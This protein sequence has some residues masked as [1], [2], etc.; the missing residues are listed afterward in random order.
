METVDRMLQVNLEREAHAHEHFKSVCT[1]M[2][3]D[4][5]QMKYFLNKIF[6]I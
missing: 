3:S 5:F 2:V 4:S 1:E 6:T